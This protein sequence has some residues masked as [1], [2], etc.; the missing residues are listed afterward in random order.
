[1]EINAVTKKQPLFQYA[2]K[3]K[4]ERDMIFF[5]KFEKPEDEQ[6]APESELT[7]LRASIKK[8]LP[9]NIAWIALKELD[10]LDK[11]DPSV[12]EYG[13][14]L[15]YV[16][17]L[18]SLPWIQATDDNLDIKRA[19]EIFTSQHY[20]LAQVKD[21][22]LEF[23]AV[24]ILFNIRSFHV[25]VVDDEEIA[26]T[27]LEYILKKEGYVV[28]TA[29]NGA[30]ALEKV[31][32]SEFDLI[33]TDLK[34]EKMDG[35]QLVESVKRVSPHTDIIMITGFATVSSAVDALKKGAAHYLPKPINLDELRATVRQILDKKKHKLMT[36]SPI[37][38]FAGPP[39]TGKTSIG[40]AIAEALERKFIRLSLAGFRDEAELR[41]HRRT[42]VGAMAGRIIN[43]I[44]RVGV[45]NPVFMLD[46]LDKIG[47]DFRGDPASVLLEILD[48]EQ[49]TQ[50]TDHY[51][52]IPFDLSSVMF[53]A[54]ANMVE[55]IPAPL[56]DRLEIIQFA[57]YTEKEKQAIAKNH[58]IP[59][60]L[61]N[62]G[63]SHDRLA[64][65]DTAITRIIRDYTQEAG[66]RN[67]EREF[68]NVCRKLA[69]ICLN[70]PDNTCV[71]NVEDS[72][73]E[74]LLGPRK[75]AHE[76]AETE[77]QVGVTTGLVWSELGGEIIFV[78]AT[79][80]KGNQQLILTGSL[81][82][83]LQESAQTA[84]SFL[85]SHG[86]DFGIQ[87]DFFKDSDIHIHFPCGAIPK[88]GPSAGITIALALISL[89]TQAPA[90]RD[91]A[92]T[93]ELTLNGR[94]LPI[95]GVREKILA[96]QRAGIKVVIFPKR[97]AVDVNNLEPES[98]EG[99][100]VV[101]ADDI[102]SIVARVI[103]QEID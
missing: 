17:F 78:E 89:L 63:L 74:Q 77:N 10:R 31:M 12:P 23:L 99:I 32:A 96:A 45:K 48:P 90:R 85:R 59:R 20:G 37:L 27:N 56:L 38:C 2:T 18:I 66:L 101:L 19:E 5:R 62:H 84:L 57:G 92:M 34:M 25:L 91:V 36:R 87:P 67:L 71:V 86:D 30:D 93:G 95:S 75:Y 9:E 33:L 70:N 81:G 50:F 61:R 52:D 100:E 13:I 8:Q 49:N 43:E 88:D 97:N 6:I 3:G 53:I 68:A 60:Q 21:R 98:C 73:V 76:I 26:R 80:M 7:Q 46:E 35:M 24:R 14:G 40:K 44:K 4:G 102:K 64:F 47:Q 58:I 39:G 41:G 11:T 54:T 72:L 22:I 42:Y 15:S 69:R 103:E 79:R 83:V 82:N 65:S 51:L 94:I 55:K 16:E 28:S 29:V 1:M